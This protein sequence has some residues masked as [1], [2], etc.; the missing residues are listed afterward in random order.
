[1]TF[2]ELLK[3]QAAVLGRAGVADAENDARLLLLYL[4][5]WEEKDR[6][7]SMEECAPE[8]DITAYRALAA[9]R[10]ERVPLQQVTGESWFYGR[11]FRVDE[12]VLI[13]RFDTEVLV[14]TVL[15]A[16]K[17]RDIR[18]LD[19]CTGSGCI[20]VTLQLEGGY[21]DVT[22]SDISEAAL[23]IAEMNA[24]V[25]KASVC[26]V[27]SDLFE[28]LAGPFDVI[29]SNPPYI[30]DDEIET[31]EPEVRDH[32]PRTALSGGPDGLYF[33]RRIAEDAGLYLKPGG[34]IYLETGYDEAAAV[35]ILFEA[36][37][38]RNGCIV[39]D[40]AGL[41]RVFT[42]VFGG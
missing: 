28:G 1:M 29:V 13:P 36:A 37:G 17:D 41:D 21:T 24:D 6:L 11:R 38:F 23:R 40:L 3:E 27:K 16:E 10:A 18:L 39:R 9:R 22:A 2:R 7:L 19:L 8:A 20:A 4:K 5:G 34:R 15:T 14:E 42:A 33:Y 12:N 30:R 31:L 32:E 26:F 25:M 35:R